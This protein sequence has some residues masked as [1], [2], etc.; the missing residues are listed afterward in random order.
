MKN[1][2]NNKYKHV[3]FIYSTQGV[4]SLSLAVV[5]GL[6]SVT[7]A[8]VRP[9]LVRRNVLS[10][11]KG[12]TSRARALSLL[13]DLFTYV[14]NRADSTSRARALNLP[15]FLRALQLTASSTSRARALSLQCVARIDRSVHLTSRARALS[16]LCGQKLVIGL[17]AHSTSRARALNGL[18]VLLVAITILAAIFTAGGGQAQAATS[19]TLNFQG[20]L[21]TNTGGLVPDGTYN[22]QFDLYY[23]A[24]G[25]SSQWTEDRLNTNSQGVVIKNGYFS[26]YLGEYDAIPALNWSEDLYLGMTIRG[27]GSCAWGACTPA[28]SQMTPRFK[29]TAVPYAFRAANVASSGTNAA[30]TNSDGVSITTGNAAGATSNSGNITVDTGTATGTTGTISLGASNA[31]ALTIGNG[32]ATTTLQGQVAVTGSGTALAVTNSATIGGTLGVTGLTTAIGGL[33]VGT[34]S[35]FINQ[36]STLFSSL[37]ISNVAGGGNIGSAATTVDVATTFNVSQTT[38]GQTLTLPNPTIAT[39]GRIAFVNNVGSTSFTMYGSVIAVGQSNTFI[40]NGTNW[41]TTVSLSGSVVNVIGTIDSASGGKSADG[42][43]IEANAIYLQTADDTYPGLVSTSAQTFAGA[44]TFNGAVLA[45]G[46][47]T[48]DTGQNFINQGSTLFSGVTV[49]DV[50][51]GGNIGSAATTV[52]IATTFNVNQTTSG[53]TLTLANPTTTTS[54]R[55]AFVNNVGSVSFEMY[56]SVI[57]SGQSNTFIWNGTNWITTVSLSGSVVNVIGTIDS[58]TKS[59]DGAV[60]SGNAIYLQTA[61]ATSVGLVSTSAQ[62]FAGAKTFNDAVTVSGLLQANLGLT[63]SGAATNLNV[64]SN[65]DTNINTGTSTG[66]VSIGNSA[67]GAVSIGSGGNIGLTTSGIIGL[68]G[69]VQLG[70]GGGLIRTSNSGA[71][72][73][74]G[75]SL[76]TGNSGGSGTQSGNISITSGNG[77]GTGTNSGNI[78]LDVGTA[79]GT[80]GTISLG[81]ANASALI[82]GRTGLTTTNAG[83]LTVTQLTTLNG[84]LTVEAGDTFTFNGD[85][86]TDLTGSGLTVVSN[87]LTVDATSAT[88]FF[89]NGGNSFGAT[90]TI[91]TNDGFALAVGTS[92]IERLRVTATGNLQ[93]DTDTLFVNATTNTVGI[94][95]GAPANPLSINTL[96]TADS[97]AQVAIGTGAVGNKGLVIQ[98]VAGQTANAL[99]VQSNTGFAGFVVSAA[100]NASAASLTVYSGETTGSFRKN[101]IA[102]TGGVSA[103]DV[104]VLADDGGASRVI[105]TTTARDTR[106]AGVAISTV[107]SGG[108]AIVA[109]AGNA[110]VTADSGAVAIGDQLV[111]SSSS[112]QVTVD[113]SATTGIVGY[114]TSSKAGGAPG[115]VGVY[116]SVTNGQLNPNFTGNI[117]VGGL[118]TLNGGLTVEAGDTFT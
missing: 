11:L 59:T 1:N 69:T 13:G 21:L 61:D 9:F 74:T 33:T 81:S 117:T 93:V 118:T 96:T 95:N 54:G 91:G 112:G 50:S 22:M 57:A 2:Q 71:G 48:V 34:G 27:T 78:T 12:S 115:T 99:E 8:V 36:G 85:A 111:T 20:R 114:A 14:G 62:T 3:L 63:A 65:F 116:I 37:A 76:L 38:G 86:F 66:A 52:D 103:A 102:G 82:L 107:S 18:G 24:S 6:I 87:A 17:R 72:S 28:D 75:I 109:I 92:G 56:G 113:N 25:G 10:H 26:V 105:R 45:S 16:G 55:I 41:V 51:G 58:Q 29:L 84:G 73:S 15:G 83:A 79:T 43:R 47:L 89:R 46:G 90:A 110:L 100:G 31:S 35:N 30:S 40:W 67:S 42:A 94:L 32:S 64:S 98:G 7:K 70:L 44:K 104:L 5:Y 106:V 19:N 108:T 97:L 88:G 101:Y 68:N 23:Q 49:N 53:Q 39:A 80:T 60:I 4:T 77:T